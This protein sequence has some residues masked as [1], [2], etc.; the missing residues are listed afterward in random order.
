MKNIFKSSKFVFES[1][2]SIFNSSNAKQRRPLKK[3]FY[4][5]ALLSRIGCH[6]W[7]ISKK[8]S[9]SCDLWIFDCWTKNTLE[10]AFER[11]DS[12]FWSLIEHYELNEKCL[13]SSFNSSRTLAD[14]FGLFS[15]CS[16]TCCIFFKWIG[17]AF[18]YTESGATFLT[19]CYHVAAFDWLSHL[20]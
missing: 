12:T 15:S 3:T 2:E 8:S 6:F 9:W 1:L 20:I 14:N 16:W 4:G 7:M 5:R 13:W 11:R 10:E 18:I 19:L 17:Y